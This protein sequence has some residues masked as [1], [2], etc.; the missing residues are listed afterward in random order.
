MVHIKK[1]KKIHSKCQNM[2]YM[3]LRSGFDITFSTLRDMG[4]R[5]NSLLLKRLQGDTFRGETVI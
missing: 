1:K 4:G 3:Q 5:R 2:R